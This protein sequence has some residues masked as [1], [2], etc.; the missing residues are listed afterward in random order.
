MVW[1][2]FKLSPVLSHRTGQEKIGTGKCSRKDPGGGL[3]ASQPP[4]EQL[5]KKSMIHGKTNGNTWVPPKIRNT[6]V[7]KTL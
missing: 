4:L 3:G 2:L 6:W 7:A 5:A 1:V